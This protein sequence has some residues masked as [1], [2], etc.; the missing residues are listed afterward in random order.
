MAEEE[1]EGEDGD[2]E[3]DGHEGS[4]ETAMGTTIEAVLAKGNDL[5]KPHH[6]VRQ[7]LGI[8]HQEVEQPTD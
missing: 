3:G 1:R 2:D 6:R 8:A 4:L 5:T 7:A